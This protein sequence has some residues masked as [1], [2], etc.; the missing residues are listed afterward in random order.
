MLARHARVF[1]TPSVCVCECGCG[2]DAAEPAKPAKSV[3]PAKPAKAAPAVAEPQAAAAAATGPW[4]AVMD[5]DG[6]GER[7]YAVVRED[8]PEGPEF[9]KGQSGRKRRFGSLE[10][11]AAAADTANRDAA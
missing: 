3:K 4:H 9:L 1:Y 11:A 6:A 8:L 7:P 5:A 10:A 2:C